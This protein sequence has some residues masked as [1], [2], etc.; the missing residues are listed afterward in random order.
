MT[1]SQPPAPTEP[2][3]QPPAAPA[4][5]QHRRTGVQSWWSSLAEWRNWRLPVKVGAVLVVPAVAAVALGAVQI[6]GDVSRA[7]SYAHVQQLVAL[8]TALTPLADDLQTERLM[9]ADKLGTPNPIN[10]P[11]YYALNTKVDRDAETVTTIGNGLLD[12][13][14]AAGIRYA[15]LLTE[16]NGLGLLHQRALT[17]NPDAATVES[18]YD[19]VIGA[20]LDFEQALSTQLGDP[21]LTGAATAMTD[22]EV[23]REQVRQQEATVIVAI[24]RGEVLANDL[25]TL[26]ASDVSLQ[27]RLEDFLVVATGDELSRY[28]QPSVTNA[29]GQRE[30]LAQAALANGQSLMT[31]GNAGGGSSLGLAPQTWTAASDAAA[32]QLTSVTSRLAGELR[33]TSAAL[34]DQ[35]STAAGIEAV[36]LFA[37]LLLAIGIGIFVGR[38]LLRS[39]AVLR[40][41]ALE[42]AEHRLPDVV[43]SIDQGN[44][45]D[46]EIEPVPVHTHEE[47][48]QLARAFD[49]VHGQAVRSAVGQATLRANLRNIFVNLSRRSQS[50]VERQLRL[51]EKLERNEEDPQQ[52]AN[53]FRL[54]HLATRMRRNNENLMVL[55][56]DDP[57]RRSGHPLPLADVLRAAV[58]EIEQY[59]RVVVRS[60]PSVDVL[61]YASGDL[62]RLIAELLD[63]ATSF[64][65]P[66]THVRIGG[67]AFP[68]GSVR[69]EIR[70]EGIGMAEPELADANGRLTADDTMDVPVSRQMGLYVVGRLAKR[71]SIQVRLEAPKE[72]GLLAVVK[73]PAELVKASAN[74]TRPSLDA[75][76]VLSTNGHSVNGH[77]GTSLSLTGK[78][79]QPSRPNLKPVS[80]WSSFTGSTMTNSNLEPTGFT[81]FNQKRAERPTPPTPTPPP[82]PTA[83][84][85]PAA[86][87]AAVSP[88]AAAPAPPPRGPQPTAEPVT[89]TSVGLPRR[90]PRSHLAPSLTPTPPPAAPPTR[91]PAR[92]RTDTPPAGQPAVAGDQTQRNPARARGFLND[93]QAGIRQGAH[94][95]Q[96]PATE[97]GQGEAP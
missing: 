81:W 5:G 74:P 54:D 79:D 56:G 85:A 78:L 53:L 92:P 40:G 27:N 8:R 97:N 37:V 64:S 42:V 77:N 69:I 66:K 9:A 67:Q 22:L 72:G 26:R 55:S 87:P 82:T 45:T 88:P 94:A 25:S 20:V 6:R 28:Q 68:D 1:A 93:Y 21:S 49:A 47:L 95:R 89:Y 96:E 41:T 35:A 4:P 46:L 65:P 71:H 80:E 15:G 39:L 14:S 60:T 50:L 13:G 16:I 30:Q 48:G 43:A 10:I 29:L 91:Q 17:G 7:N 75:T 58:S 61:G 34:Q 24:Y 84:P 90:V 32:T 12:P 73:V 31:V 59:Q 51:M 57:A 83:P 44:L 23:A 19:A 38:H 33:D 2:V 76:V 62:V 36:V 3:S 86:P 70:D 52:L 63:N 18:E 11:A